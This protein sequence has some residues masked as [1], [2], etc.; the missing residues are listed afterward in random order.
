MTEELR[1]DGAYENAFLGVGN[2]TDRSAYTRAAATVKL[3]QQ[4]LERLYE[5][6]GLARRIIDLPAREM[7]RAGFEIEGVEDDKEVMTALENIGTMAAIGEALTWANLFGGSIIVMIIRDGGELA[8]PVNLER[9]TE[10]EALR[11]YD[12]HSATRFKTYNDPNDKRFGK[13]EIWNISPP[14]GT[15]YK[16]H[17]TRCLTFDGALVPPRVREENDG[18]GGSVMQHTVDTLTRFEMSH[19]WTNAL[20]ERAQQ[21][22]HGIP[23]LT[24]LLR[25]PDGE[26]LVKK[27]IALVDM[28]RSINNTV[29]IDS[30]ETYELKAT[31]LSGVADLIDRFS[32]A[33]SAVTGI[34]ESLLFGRQ[35][36]GLSNSNNGDLENWYAS[37]AQ[38]QNLV[39]LTPLDRLVTIQLYALGL[40]TDEYLIK[41]CPLSVPS[42]KETAETRKLKAETAKIYV[43]M[44]ALDPSEVRKELDD[45]GY[46]INEVKLEGEGAGDGEEDDV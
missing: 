31:P 1:D 13:T 45:E 39:L 4:E 8:D 25:N 20:L 44:Q 41:F 38:K 34:P 14:L 16:V 35:K 2:R 32:L 33:L 7:V 22:V 6:G 23:E 40:Y 28:A 26:A 30:S 17:E 9:V 10:I 15:P 46:E 36:A 3:G 37:I 42:E 29:V 18:W 43:D 24:N 12:R 5:S 21:A 11:V 27:R 19:Y